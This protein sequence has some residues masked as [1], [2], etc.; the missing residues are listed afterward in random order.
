MQDLLVNVLG[1]H[2]I[3]EQE[4]E[5]IGANSTFVALGDSVFEC[6]VQIRARAA[7]F[8]LPGR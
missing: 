2:V 4:N 7:K 5:L 1:G 3:H 8:A 6:A